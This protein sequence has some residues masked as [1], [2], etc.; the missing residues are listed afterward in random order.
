MQIDPFTFE[1]FLA[2][3]QAKKAFTFS[4]WGDGEWR[5]VLGS[6]H[7]VNC[8]G[9]HYFPEMGNELRAVLVGKPSYLL[10]M[11]P[12]AQ[13][14]YG[15]KIESFLKQNHLEELRW[16]NSDVIHRGAIRGKMTELLAAVNAWPLIVVGPDHLK[17]AHADLRYRAFVGV[18]PRNCYLAVARIIADVLNAADA[19]PSPGLI[20]VSAS[21]PAEIIIDH[22]HRRLNGRHTLIDFGSV[23]DPL[24]GVRS[25]SYMKRNQG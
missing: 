5:S 13:R 24:A 6:T 19:L 2:R 18:P 14:M 25:R 20:S 9:H 4:R 15:S 22:L 16:V 3:L 1:D 23:W 8:D 11:Q 12:M 10:G 17:R 7:G 21:M